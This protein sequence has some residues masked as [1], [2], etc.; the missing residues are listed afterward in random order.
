M[1]NA[2]TP[3]LGKRRARKYAMLPVT[4]K[5]GQQGHTFPEIADALGVCVMTA[6]H[7]TRVGTGASPRHA[8]LRPEHAPL[9][10]HL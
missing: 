5:W 10:G 8:D 7:W 2:S 3:V 1:V 4:R 9:K 6:W